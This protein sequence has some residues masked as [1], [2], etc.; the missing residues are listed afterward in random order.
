MTSWPARSSGNIRTSD[1]GTPQI[2]QVGWLPA[3]A[4]APAAAYFFA[5]SSHIAR[6]RRT[7]SGNSLMV[8][9]L[10]G[11]L[12]REDSLSHDRTQLTVAF[13]LVVDEL[14]SHPRVP[15]ISQMR[16]YR[17]NRFMMMLGALEKSA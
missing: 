4:R 3:Q 5:Q 13:A 7:C 6:L 11:S 2:P 8:L 16:G 12:D 17:R 1:S 15:E 14:L 10:P 9:T